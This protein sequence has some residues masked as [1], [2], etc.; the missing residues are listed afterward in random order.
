M[1][2]DWIKLEHT[3]PDKEE[4]V[5]MATTLQL[6]QDS[7][8]GK[9]IRLWIW[10]DQNSVDGNALRVT[11]TFLDRLTNCPGF[12]NALR[13]VGWLLGRDGRLAIPN[14]CRHNGQSAKRRALTKDRVGALRVAQSQCNAVSVTKSVPEKRREEVHP[15]TRARE[16]DELPDKAT[17]IAQS[18]VSGVAEDFAVYVFDDWFGR[19]G[20]DAAGIEV[21]W[22]HYVTKRWTR[23]RKE[24]QHGTHK[25]NPHTKTVN[26]SNTVALSKELDRVLDRM[27]TIKGTYGDHQS[28]S[29]DDVQEFNKLRV[30]RGE[31]RQALGV[32]V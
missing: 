27:K 29:P 32:Q 7:V 30:R 21:P 3:T 10:A 24:W 19:G 20:L 15:T 17:A 1:A 22:L 18:A 23:E 13:E 2:G 5:Q 8:V 16:G 4:V 26:G 11:D 28:W 9:C 12:A 25:G 14:F 31:L 6:D